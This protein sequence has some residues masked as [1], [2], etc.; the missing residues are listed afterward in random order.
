MTNAIY[1]IWLLTV[2][3]TV[4]A[5]GSSTPPPREP[6][7]LEKLHAAEKDARHAL[8]GGELQ[9]AQHSFNKALILQQSLDDTAG[10]AT[11]MIN[12]ATVAHQLHEDEAALA[13]LDKILLERAPLYPADSQLT[14]AF[15]K[16]VIL[17][18]LGRFGEADTSL[19]LAEKSC[20]K[21]CSQRFN[22]DTLRARI[23]L[24][25]G[26]AETALA[27]AQIVGKA[28][29]A[30]KEEQANALRVQ[31]GAEE[32]LQRYADALTHY[33]SALE[34]DKP[35]GLSSRIAEDLNGLARTA[36]LLGR[37][38]DAAAYARRASL[39]NETKDKSVLSAH[40]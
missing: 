31:A 10:A 9:R 36:K 16:A 32:K 28:V 29:E 39:V 15:R 25:N 27:L 34:M 21:K 1:K 22:I 38:Q 35:L 7:L 24:L 19:Q 17:T 30:G 13:W 20:E 5:C 40:E 23:F 33:Q 6:Q 8:N 26:N 37:E 12:L 4:T 14:A 11:T 2:L 3:F 18:N